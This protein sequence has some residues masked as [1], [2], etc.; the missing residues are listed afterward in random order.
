MT[1]VQTC[2]L[3]IS[4]VTTLNLSG[5]GANQIH[6][7]TSINGPTS[8]IGSPSNGT[9][10]YY[11]TAGGFQWTVATGASVGTANIANYETVT[12]ATSGTYYPALYSATS[13]NQQVYANNALS[14]NAAT[15]ALSISSQAN[16]SMGAILFKDNKAGNRGGAVCLTGSTSV[17]IRR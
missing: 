13:G 10:L 15:G 12:N 11:T 6:Y 3:P 2:A 16:G 5:G 7:Q 8:F 9:F 1:G 14:L 4:N 17:L